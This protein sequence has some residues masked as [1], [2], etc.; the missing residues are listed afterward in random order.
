MK[1]KLFLILICLVSFNLYAQNDEDSGEIRTLLNGEHSHGGY[2][3]F[4]IRYDEIDNKEG[5]SIG[6]RFGWIIDHNVTIG[7]GGRGFFTESAKYDIPNQLG[8]EY[9][10]GGGYGGIFI[11]PI[12]GARYPI[13]ISIPLFVGAGGVAFTRKFVD[14]FNHDNDESNFIDSDAFFFVEPGVEIEINLIRFMRIAFGAYYRYTSEITLEDESY[15]NRKL[16]DDDILKGMT[17]GVTI[18]FGKF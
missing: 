4:S 12:I 11:E 10:L 1:T 2:G 9:N 18:K 14:D 5:M 13:H 6:G 15:P 17:F 8:D 3:A 7:L 16:V